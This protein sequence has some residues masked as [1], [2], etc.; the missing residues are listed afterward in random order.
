MSSR[1]LYRL[2]GGTLIVG[3]L[4]ILIGT[5]MGA[6]LFP[7]HSSTQEQVLSFPWLFMTLIILVGALLFA[8]GLSGMY[9]RQAG[10]A[11]VLGLVGFILLFLAMLLQGTAFS[12][13]QIVVLPFLA[14]KAP[15]LMGGN[16]LPISAFLLL[17]IS[18]L[19]QIVGDILLGIATMRA[20]V[21]PRWTGILLLISGIAFL[22]TLPPLPSP[23]SDLIETASF[24]AFA[25]VFLWCGYLLIASERG[26]VEAAPFAAE[27][28]VSH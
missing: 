20:R 4:F 5:I 15:Q 23:I 28:R 27:A 2:S 13:V 14:Q 8:I 18:G 25:I 6:V 26:S 17:I 11:G 3:S 22:L 19:M 16:S 24:V 10:R 9:L 7:G 12:A 1:S 21:F